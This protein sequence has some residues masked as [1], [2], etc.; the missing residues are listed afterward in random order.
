MAALDAAHQVVS[1]AV[2]LVREFRAG[3]RTEHTVIPALLESFPWL[4]ADAAKVHSPA[5]LPAKDLSSQVR[6]FAYYV[7]MK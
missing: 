3:T 6:T 4:G 7:V 2:S 1:V 5:A